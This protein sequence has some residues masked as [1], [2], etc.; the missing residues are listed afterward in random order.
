MTKMKSR[1][2]LQIG[3]VVF[4]ST[5][6][7]MGVYSLSEAKFAKNKVNALEHKNDSIVSQNVMKVI[8]TTMLD[9]IIIE[10][11]KDF[12]YFSFDN[13]IVMQHTRNVNEND[14]IISRPVV[15]MSKKELEKYYSQNGRHKSQF[16]RNLMNGTIEVIDTTKKI[17]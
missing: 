11:I 6:I 17:K 5:L 7:G 8:D 12:R 14:S 16:Y 15:F 9:S 13:Y 10:R 3:I 4:L 2:V 1:A